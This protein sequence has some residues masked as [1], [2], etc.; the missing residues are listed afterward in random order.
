MKLEKHVQLLKSLFKGRED[1]FE[2]RWEK[3]NKSGYMPLPISTK[4]EYY[5]CLELQ[6]VSFPS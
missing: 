6:K 3:A 5:V 1:V 2:L 4:P